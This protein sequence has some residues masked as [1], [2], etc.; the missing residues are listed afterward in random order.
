[1]AIRISSG[2]SMSSGAD[3]TSPRASASAASSGLPSGGA[4]RGDRFRRAVMAVLQSRRAGDRRVEAEID[5]ADGD[6]GRGAIRRRPH[7]GP[8]G[9]ERQLQQRPAKQEPRSISAN[10][11]RDDTSNR[12]S[13]RRRSPIVS[14]TN[15][16]FRCSQS[17]R[18][19]SSTAC[20][21]PC[22]RSSQVPISSSFVRSDRIASS[23]SRAMATA[24]TRRPLRR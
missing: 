7:I 23:S 11:V 3:V 16:W 4:E 21:S 20:G 15:Q 6:A 10:S 1:M 13:A 22:V 5:R 17:A 24:T 12:A 18:S 9:R 2:Q 14:R 8:V 19:T